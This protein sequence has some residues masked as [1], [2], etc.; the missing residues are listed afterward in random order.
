MKERRQWKR[1]EAAYPVEADNTEDIDIINVIDVSKGGIG[2]ETHSSL[3]KDEE[4]TLRIF[5]KKRMFRLKAVV[6][7]S[8]RLKENDYTVGIQFIDPPEDFLPTLEKE[9]NDI[10]QAYREKKLYK[11]KDT[12]FK[13]SSKE[14]LKTSKLKTLTLDT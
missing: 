12:S 1:Y 6:A 14:Y 5:L 7:Y 2:Y 10:T 4:I 8:K 11:H 3:G 13:D 9:L